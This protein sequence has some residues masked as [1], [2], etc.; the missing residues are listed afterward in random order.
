LEYP[1]VTPTR[2][3]IEKDGN[4]ILINTAEGRIKHKNVSRDPRVAISISDHNNPYN[5]VSIRGRVIEQITEGAD[6]HTNRLAKKYLG[7]D[8]YPYR[9]P[10]EKRVILRI[11]PEKVFYQQPP[12]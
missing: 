2:V 9:S 10:S 3:D 4:S 5:M 7:V 6:E 12:K 8:K 1:Q 11:K